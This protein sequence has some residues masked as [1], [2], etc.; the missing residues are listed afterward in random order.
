MT[1]RSRWAAALARACLGAVALAGCA[2]G[3]VGDG[4]GPPPPPRDLR[5]ADYYPLDAGWRWAYDLEKDGQ[6]ILAM[7]GV[8]ERTPD[9]A[10]VQAGDDRL[11][12]AIAPDGIAQKEGTVLGD[13]VIKDPVK[14]GAEWPVAGGKAKIVSVSEQVTTD[15]GKFSGCAVVE[16]TREAPMRIARTTFAPGVGPVVIEMHVVTG[17]GFAT[18]T[19]ATLRAVTRPGED[20]LAGH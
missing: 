5:A 3:G 17:A 2:T 19:R 6:K 11:M 10:I 14:A 8:L 4:A 7:Y 20:P 13:F 16:V 1:A 15:A 12:Y 18:V 9:T